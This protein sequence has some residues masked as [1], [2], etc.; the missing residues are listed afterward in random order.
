MDNSSCLGGGVAQPPLS[1]KTV[2]S[3]QG[4]G[5]QAMIWASAY[6]ITALTELI[7]K[8][9]LLYL[10]TFLFHTKVQIVSHCHLGTALFEP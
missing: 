5:L 3:S 9:I 8:N 2:T 1:F 6:L 10:P 4:S 7:E